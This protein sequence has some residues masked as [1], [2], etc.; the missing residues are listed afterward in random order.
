M[1]EPCLIYVGNDMFHQAVDAR[2][3]YNMAAF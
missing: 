2:F 3:C 1:N